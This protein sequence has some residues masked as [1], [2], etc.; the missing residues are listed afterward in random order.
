MRRLGITKENND[1]INLPKAQPEKQ[2]K[3]KDILKVKG[4]QET[5]LVVDDEE[6]VL[7]LLENTLKKYGYNVKTATDG[8]IALDIYKEDK[9]LIDAVI[10][11][12]TMPKMSGEMLLEKMLEINPDVKVIISSGHSEE[13]IQEEVLTK[14]KGYVKKPYKLKNIVQ[15]LRT[16]LDL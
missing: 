5:I 9:D 15:I 16:V 4:G 14:A 10:L 2:I 8:D 11:D 13:D 12:L 7:G 3:S 6:M 1:Y